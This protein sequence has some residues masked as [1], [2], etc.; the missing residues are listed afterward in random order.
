[1]PEDLPVL[2]YI[3]VMVGIIRNIYLFYLYWFYLEI[4]SFE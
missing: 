3:D 4:F 2:K 1:M